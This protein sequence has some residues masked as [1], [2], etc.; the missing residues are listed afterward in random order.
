MVRRWGWWEFLFPLPL[1]TGPLME[2]KDGQQK[3]D[4][5]ILVAPHIIRW[6]NLVPWEVTEAKNSASLKE[7]LGISIDKKQ[8]QLQYKC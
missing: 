1:Q 8:N 6:Q 7:D 4:K 3:S 5:E 2:C